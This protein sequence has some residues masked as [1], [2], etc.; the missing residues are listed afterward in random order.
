VARVHISCKSTKLTVKMQ[1]LLGYKKMFC[2]GACMLSPVRRELIVLQQDK[3]ESLNCYK[4][5]IRGILFFLLL[6]L[7]RRRGIL[8][9]F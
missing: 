2:S 1:K 4:A 6:M 9:R 8:L 5:N 7:F 3:K